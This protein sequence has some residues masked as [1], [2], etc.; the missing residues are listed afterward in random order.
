MVGIAAA[1]RGYLANGSTPVR[2]APSQAPPYSY[3][4]TPGTYQQGAAFATP[5][6]AATP[7]AYVEEAYDT[8]EPLVAAA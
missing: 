5:V 8:G 7:A 3:A 4:P 6:P 1:R 2:A